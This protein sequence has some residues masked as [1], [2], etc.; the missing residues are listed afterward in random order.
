MTGDI[1]PRL[2]KNTVQFPSA[3]LP[4]GKAAQKSAADNSRIK[5]LHLR[6]RR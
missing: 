5:A 3:Q 4:G 2:K 1:L 6:K